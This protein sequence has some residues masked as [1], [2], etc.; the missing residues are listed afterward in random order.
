MSPLPSCGVYNGRADHR[1]T[2]RLASYVEASQDFHEQS[3]GQRDEKN[4]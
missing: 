3:E 4:T 1:E 2:V